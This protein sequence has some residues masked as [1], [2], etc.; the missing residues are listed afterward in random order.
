MYGARNDKSL[1]ELIK[2]RDYSSPAIQNKLIKVLESKS[3]NSVLFLILPALP[4][5]S[6]LSNFNPFPFNLSSFSQFPLSLPLSFCPSF[7]PFLLPSFHILSLHY[8]LLPPS[9]FI[10]FLCY[11]FSTFL[12][13]FFGP[14]FLSA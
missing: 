10:S 7:L 6:S 13:F 8:F 5:L 1:G 9:S 11:F 4:S 12:S 14:Y 3:V 2:S